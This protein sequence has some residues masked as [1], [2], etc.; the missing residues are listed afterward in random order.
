VAAGDVFRLDGDPVK[1]HVLQEDRSTVDGEIGV[2]LWCRR[3]DWRGPRRG[4][5]PLARAK[6]GVNLGED[7]CF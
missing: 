2:L 5:L 7:P 1:G 4:Q 3:T 6:S